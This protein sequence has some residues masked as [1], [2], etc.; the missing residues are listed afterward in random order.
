MAPKWYDYATR[1]LKKAEKIEKNFPGRLDDEYGHLMISNEKLFFV[2]E[3]GFLTKKYSVTLNLPF[4]NIESIHHED[5][6]VLKIIDKSGKVHDFRTEA[7]ASVVDKSL[8]EIIK[9]H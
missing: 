4:E 3:E 1:S 7:S 8:N 2:K 9:H 5:R 6:Y